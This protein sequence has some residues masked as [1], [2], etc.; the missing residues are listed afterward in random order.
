MTTDKQAS[1]LNDLMD[2]YNDCRG[3]NITDPHAEIARLRADNERLS[4]IT[5]GAAQKVARAEEQAEDTAAA[6]MA[7][8]G[9]AKQ[10]TTPGNSLYAPEPAAEIF[11]TLRRFMG[12][13]VLEAV[14]NPA[15]IRAC[16]CDND[17]IECSHEA[18]RGNA[19]AAL[20]TLAGRLLEMATAWDERLPATI[21][22]DTAAAAIRETIRM[23][24][25]P[26]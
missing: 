1:D 14:Q 2:A 22:S 7:V 21:R 9:L 8:T 13:R 12:A 18:A 19:E 17:P 11:T 26:E 24:R 23:I 3:H 4:A 5:A 6:L 20:N 16:T 25:R 15:A 10:W